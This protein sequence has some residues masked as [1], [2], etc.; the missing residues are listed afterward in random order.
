MPNNEMWCRKPAKKIGEDTGSCNLDVAAAFS[1]IGIRP[2]SGDPDG[3]QPLADVTPGSVSVH[4]PATTGKTSRTINGSVIF[5]V[6]AIDPASGES[7]SVFS[8]LKR[9]TNGTVVVKAKSLAS[10]KRSIKSG[11]TSRSQTWFVVR[12]GHPC[13]VR[14]RKANVAIRKYL[15]V[16]LPR[17]SVLFRA[18]IDLAMAKLKDRLERDVIVGDESH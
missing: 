14:G 12:K 17:R 3:W 7:E 15:A 10:T 1:S 2:S 13:V 8:L 4:L 9:A 5:S 16:G 11:R 18:E 6:G